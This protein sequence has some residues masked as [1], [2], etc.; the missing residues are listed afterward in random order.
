MSVQTPHSDARILLPDPDSLHW[1]GPHAPGRVVDVGGPRG[2]G[3]CDGPRVV[4]P[5]ALVCESRHEGIVPPL[6]GREHGPA[7]V[8]GPDEGLEPGAKFQVRVGRISSVPVHEVLEGQSR[9]GLEVVQCLDGGHS[10]L[11]VPEEVDH[12]PKRDDLVVDHDV[13]VQ[14]RFHLVLVRHGS[15]VEEVDV[16]AINLLG[17]EHGED[18]R[19]QEEQHD[20]GEVGLLDR[21]LLLAVV[22]AAVVRAGVTFLLQV[23]LGDG[24]LTVDLNLGFGGRGWRVVGVDGC[25][26]SRRKT[27]HARNENC[28]RPEV[29][30]RWDWEP[31]KEDV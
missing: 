7:P 22:A 20:V 17:G 29:A 24:A 5:V 8:G 27:I 28:W 19:V 2:V 18:L 26:I 14:P 1:E 30:F 16:H 21:A 11:N 12:L 9:T 31:E 25:H 6:T 13:D 23:G 15:P 10:G 3:V 4:A